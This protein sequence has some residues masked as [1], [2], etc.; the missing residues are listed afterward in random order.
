[1]RSEGKRPAHAAAA[2]TR[3]MQHTHV[4][5]TAWTRENF[6]GRSESSGARHGSARPGPRRGARVGAG[7]LL[8]GA[9][10]LSSPGAAAAVPPPPPNPSDAQLHDAQGR[11][12]QGIGQI[13]ELINRIAEADQQLQQLVG[14]VEAK[15]E[16]ANK[17][18]VDL[19]QARGV[20]QRA[21]TAVD[22]AQRQL[23]HAGDAIAHAQQEFEKF[24]SASYQDGV[25]V[26]SLTMFL[27]SSGPD[28]VLDRA[29]L[30]E[31]VRDQYR[32]AMEKLQRAQVEKANTVSQ[33]KAAQVKADAAAD[34]AARK[35]SAAQQA[36]DE[37]EQAQQQQQTK[38]A[39]IKA[40][41][42]EAEQQLAHAR[43]DVD[44]LQSQRDVYQQWEQKKKA[45]Q[46]AEEAAA[47]A[48]KKAARQA[49]QR[50]AADDAAE[51]AAQAVAD[52]QEKG[53]VTGT[54]DN[55]ASGRTASE[56]IETVIDRGMSQLGVTY[57]WGGGN[58]QGPTLG[59]HD[60]GV[61][62]EH[63]DFEKVGYDCSGLMVYAFAGVG[64]S[65]PKYSGYQ[66]TAGKQVPVSQAKRG[67]MLFWGPNG[68]QHVALFLG[69][70]KMLE[71][72]FS[73]G[74]VRVAPV[75]WSGIEPY[76]VR[77]IT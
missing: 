68:S 62:D 75:R 52:S 58:A 14:R 24:I 63:G 1:M 28:D 43:N 60:G 10:F 54:V 17:A 59:V 67:D 22:Q 48:A 31:V 32:Q 11:V 13:S 15:R 73:G 4:P 33:S 71:A 66:Y 50:A 55:A 26:G 56:K 77:M 69:D 64:V 12:D 57:A 36:I 76:A 29:R 7:V 18:L 6:V 19:Q 16:A 37:A 42:H 3:A 2:G 9:M 51:A 30:M 74:V 61:A 27:G 39:R 40:D 47:Q 5:I 21:A 46:A 41:K 49:A 8:A 65:L 35:K 53:H 72:P 44:G 38:R 23:S 25:P 20:A 34:D 70:G 45:E